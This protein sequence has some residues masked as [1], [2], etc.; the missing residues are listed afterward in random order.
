[1]KKKILSVICLMLAALMLCS[2][3][4]TGTEL[5]GSRGTSAYVKTGEYKKIVID[6][7]SDEYKKY[8][9]ALYLSDIAAADLFEKVES[10]AVQNGD[11][12]NINF[13]GKVEGAYFDG[14]TSDNYDLLI[15]SGTFIS[16]FEEGL[17]GVNVGET[18][19]LNLKFPEN[20]DNEQ[21][22]GKDVVFTVT[23]NYRRVPKKIEEAYKEL[24]YK[25]LDEYKQKLDNK[26]KS[27]FAIKQY[28]DSCSV[29]KVPESDQF[30]AL[31]LMA[32]YDDYLKESKNI[33]F[34]EHAKQKGKTI[35]EYMT[36]VINHTADNQI[37][38]V[39]ELKIRANTILAYYALFE[40]EKLQLNESELKD[41]K[42]YELCYYEYKQIKTSC[43]ELLNKNAKFK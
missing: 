8:Y 26:C 19:D 35:N 22:N 29:L 2:C 34:A 27:Y 10:G 4:G 9:N 30:T 23:V 21:L 15:G 37:D 24:G 31:V 40:T 16:G 14:G 7:K 12:A 36:D 38:S 25:T 5:F 13:A 39:P 20:Y 42:D 41:K 32:Y 33:D 6:K 1:M 11:Y 17:I 28:I 18:V 43:E 3:G